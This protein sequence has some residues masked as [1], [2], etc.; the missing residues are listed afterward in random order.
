M[1]TYQVLLIKNNIELSWLSVLN[2]SIG[3]IA[4]IITLNELNLAQE[5][6]NKKCNLILINMASIANV[7]E[8]IK[9][10][11]QNKPG[12]P[13]VVITASPNSEIA[14][15]VFRAGASDYLRES[16][17]ETEIREELLGMIKQ[18][19]DNN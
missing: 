11:K 7:E 16:I 5:I 10:S 2:K 18:P 14:R 3:D 8:V 19:V 15:K 6:K 12:V 4:E 17:D 9:T 1:S 13:I